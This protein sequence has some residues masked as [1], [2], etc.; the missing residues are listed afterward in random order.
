MDRFSALDVLYAEDFD[1]PAAVLAEPEPETAAPHFTLAE[2]HAAREA[3]F[4]AGREAERD[5]VVAEEASARSRAVAALAANLTEARET[6]RTHAEAAAEAL[7]QAVLSI[8]A[9]ALP[10]LCAQHGEAEARAM[11]QALLPTLAAE[12]RI[13]VRLSPGLVDA[14]QA[15]LA[16]LDP[17]VAALVQLM[18]TDTMPPGDVRVSWENGA[19]HRSAAAA[20]AAVRRVLAPLDLL[21]PEPV[22]AQEL[23]HAQ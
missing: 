1:G 9:A 21:L 12:P 23:V 7:A 3:G 15:D 5:C 14:V 6:A 17:D 8:I 22:F 18:P 20:C 2:F 10:S 4:A 16:V 19:C 11:L 13:A